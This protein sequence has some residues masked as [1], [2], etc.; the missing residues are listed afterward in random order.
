[1]RLTYSR[2]LATLAAVAA[3]GLAAYS[4]RPVSPPAVIAARAPAVQYRTEV[5]HRTIHVVK[6]ERSGRFPV[7]RGAV[8]TGGGHPASSRGV[9]TGASGSHGS[10]GTSGAAAGG[11]ATRA[12]GHASTGAT[13]YAGGS[14]SAPVA[15]RTSGS[16]TSGSAGGSSG[17]SSA[18][19]STRTSGGAGAK[20][21][22]KGDGGGD[23]GGD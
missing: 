2:S 20:S 9:R 11:V 8:A 18:P 16:H 4:L 7:P 22:E 10:S 3:A 5:I 19:V 17:T 23:G 21:G 6:H 14:G 1:M 13:V 15:T 12:S